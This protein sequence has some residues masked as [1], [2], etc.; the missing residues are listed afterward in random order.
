MWMSLSSKNSSARSRIRWLTATRS[1]VDGG[2]Q[3]SMAGGRDLAHAGG[4]RVMRTEVDKD[5]AQATRTQQ[6][7]ERSGHSVRLVVKL[8]GGSCPQREEW[9]YEHPT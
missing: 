9:R 1:D 8:R 4:G 6:L 2:G 5:A 7:R 3:A